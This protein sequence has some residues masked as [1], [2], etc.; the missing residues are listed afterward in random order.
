MRFLSNF[1]YAN[2]NRLLV[3][4]GTV[5]TLLIVFFGAFT[6]QSLHLPTRNYN[7]TDKGP[8]YIPRCLH[9]QA[10]RTPVNISTLIYHLIMST[11]FYRVATSHY[12]SA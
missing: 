11:L 2:R 1:T 10:G 5:N 8:T 12:R 3:W 6:Q 9:Y 7:V 4:L